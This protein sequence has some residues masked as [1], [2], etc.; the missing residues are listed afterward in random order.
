MQVCIVKLKSSDMEFLEKIFKNQ[1]KVDMTLLNK[2]KNFAEVSRDNITGVIDV[3]SDELMEYGFSENSEP[4][5][6]GLKVENL[7]DKINKFRLECP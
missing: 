6:Y 2:I 1:K 5:E 7:L 3:I 4:N